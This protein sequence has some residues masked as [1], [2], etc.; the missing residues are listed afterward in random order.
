MVPRPGQAACRD[1]VACPLL[2]SILRTEFF[3]V[4]HMEQNS[5]TEAH[6]KFRFVLES[7]VVDFTSLLSK[8][9]TV[10]GCQA[11]PPRHLL[12]RYIKL[13]SLVV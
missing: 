9:L 8:H 1:R 12:R 4:P 5:A 6:T 11:E 7:M 10:Q 13:L 2:D 3:Q